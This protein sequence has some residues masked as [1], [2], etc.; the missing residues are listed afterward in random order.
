MHPSIFKTC[1][2]TSYVVL[3]V[4]VTKESLSLRV[5]DEKQIGRHFSQ[6]ELSELFEYSPAEQRESSD[7]SLSVPKVS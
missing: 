6:A 5:V 2:I 1:Y 4:Q 7:P 3:Y